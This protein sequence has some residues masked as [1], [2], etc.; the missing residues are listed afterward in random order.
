MKNVELIAIPLT[1]AYGASQ[2]PQTEGG[3]AG[4]RRGKQRNGFQASRD[5]SIGCLILNITQ[6]CDVVATACLCPR[7]SQKRARMATNDCAS[8]K[9]RKLRYDVK[10]SHFQLLL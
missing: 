7:Q 10:D 2:E 8:Y 9:K 1:P 6:Y 3:R 5:V 4:L